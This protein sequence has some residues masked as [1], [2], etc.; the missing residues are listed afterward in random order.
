MEIASVLHRPFTL[1]LGNST[2]PGLEGPGYPPRFNLPQ[3]LL[4]IVY[5]GRSSPFNVAQ[6]ADTMMRQ[7]GVCHGVMHLGSTGLSSLGTTFLNDASN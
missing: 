3:T 4:F 6:V 7:C 2:S 1:L 5:H